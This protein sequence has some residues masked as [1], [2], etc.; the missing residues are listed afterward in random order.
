MTEIDGLWSIEFQNNSQTFGAGV[1]VINNGRILGGDSVF[2][3]NGTL[4]EENAV[5]HGD[6]EI[7]KHCSSDISIFGSRSIFGSI[8]H[9][10]LK[11]VG[12]SDTQDLMLEGYMVE[13]PQQKINIRAVH[14]VA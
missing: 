7:S 13:N 1:I 9:F 6:L 3:Y 8:D 10:H 5:I 4:K 11:I 2:M 14:R 12:S